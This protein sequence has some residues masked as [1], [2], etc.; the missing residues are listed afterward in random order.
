MKKYFKFIVKDIV[1]VMLGILLAFFINNW[2]E[3]KKEERYYK[4]ILTSIKKELSDTKVDIEKTILK[5]KTLI[6]TLNFYSKN[7]EL[8]ILSLTLKV[9]GIKIPTVKINSWKAISSSKIELFDYGNLSN[10]ANIE[11]KKDHLTE[12]GNYLMDFLY[13]NISDTSKNKKFVLKML[14]LDII[15]TENSILQEIKQIE[16]R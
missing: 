14:M 2:N 11:E 12:K 1:P 9:D 10:L 7:K 4:K 5:Q 8:S 13:S 16:N 3:G 15:N 6:D